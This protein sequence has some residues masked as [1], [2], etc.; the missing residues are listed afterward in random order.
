MRIRLMHWSK[1]VVLFLG[2]LA[3]IARVCAAADL[4]LAYE[5]IEP[6][7]IR[8]GE[9]AIIRVTSLDGYLDDVPLPNVTGLKFEVVARQQGFEFVSGKPIQSS[10]VLIRVT[11]EFT[12]VF[13]IPG[14]TPKS[15][16]L[17]LEVVAAETNNPLAWRS[18]KSSTPPPPPP[19]A[20]ASLPKGVELKAGGA[21]FVRLVIPTRDI[22]VGESVP[23]DIEVGLRPGI[24][25]SL[26]GCPRSPAATSR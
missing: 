18:Y 16:T 3:P 6:P 15:R 23:V 8:I 11:P 21:A 24:V 17:G 14:L 2:L 19:K 1:L 9:S 10:Y 26:N 12:G 7:S 13:T 20:T 5:T 25:T 22:Y 4:S